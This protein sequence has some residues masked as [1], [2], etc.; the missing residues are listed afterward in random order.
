MKSE[1]WVTSAY[2]VTKVGTIAISR[3]PCCVL[4]ALSWNTTNENPSTDKLSRAINYIAMRYAVSKGTP[5]WD[6]LFPWAL[7][8][9]IALDPP[10]SPPCV[11]H[12]PWSTFFLPYCFIFFLDIYTSDI[13]LIWCECDYKRPYALAIVAIQNW[14]DE[15]TFNSP[16]THRYTKT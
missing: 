5:F 12:T 14:T 15:S 8:A 7:I 13:Y 4:L 16:N 6:V 1:K 2:L 11:K 10:P 3:F 9:K